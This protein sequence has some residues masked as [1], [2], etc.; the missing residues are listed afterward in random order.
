[1]RKH[2]DFCDFCK[3]G[4]CTGSCADCFRNDYSPYGMPTNFVSK[5]KLPQYVKNS[6]SKQ[7]ENDKDPRMICTMPHV[8]YRDI[9]DKVCFCDNCKNNA[10]MCNSCYLNE[11]SSKPNK[12]LPIK[13]V[14]LSEYRGYYPEYDTENKQNKLKV[15]VRKVRR[16]KKVKKGI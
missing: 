5:Y 13:F 3:H 16:I 6:I 10:K 4:E 2:F 1:M 14:N 12:F 9:I 15:T 7:I 11:P 8:G